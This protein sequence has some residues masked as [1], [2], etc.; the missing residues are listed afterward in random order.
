MYAA[1][2]EHAPVAL[3]VVDHLRRIKV[4][5][6]ASA[7]LFGYEVDELIGRPIEVLVAPRAQGRHPA[8]S[9]AFLDAPA[10]RPMGNGSELYGLRKDGSEIPVEVNLTP[11]EWEGEAYVLGSIVDLSA[12]LRAEDH[13][14]TA[15]EAAPNA[16][17]MIDSAGKIVLINGQTE[18]IFGYTRHELVGQSIEVLVPDEM[19][20][21]HRTLVTGFM[22]TPGP[23]PM[24]FGRDLVARHKDGRRF[25]VEIGL[26]PIR[27]QNG[28]Y[29]ISSIV[30]ISERVRVREQ[31]MQRND[32]L[33]QF[34]YRT[35]HDL[36][37][38][39]L[40]VNGLA[41]FIIEDIAENNPTEAAA[42]AGKILSLSARLSELV[43]GI[44]ALT[45][46]DH[47][48]EAR[49]EIDLESLLDGTRE[50]LQVAI[51]DNGV[52]VE[53]LPTH[54]VPLLAQPTRVAQIID[55]LVS[56]AVRYADPDKAERRV[57]M[58]SAANTER[59]LLTIE[60]NGIG[61]PEHRHT[62]VFG[63]F[64]RF[65]ANR[66]PGSGLGLHLV[67]RHVQRLGGTITFESSP[68]GTCFHVSLPQL[69]SATRE[70]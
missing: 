62:E 59:F 32:E 50:K 60:D 25:P 54:T 53:F 12:R 34:A 9:E 16:M 43:E 36:R 69:P 17:V 56:N 15:V 65:H 68:A 29:M 35:S 26:R 6:V 11:I 22:A 61:I 8:L 45:R 37:A 10:A 4:A 38:P 31:L 51:R 52:R 23:R 7:R 33:E 3:V 18:A 49:V 19:R 27:G 30:D 58:R 70:A 48:D 28:D 55:N 39:L 66:V 14:R 42:N 24:G 41:E 47:V 57:T 63:I 64:K 2:F 46:A 20:A 5:N 40:S 67:K 21:R 13:F 1:I 44:L